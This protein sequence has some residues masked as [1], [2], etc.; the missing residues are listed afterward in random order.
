MRKMR[1]FCAQK[2]FYMNLKS[3]FMLGKTHVPHRK[4]TAGT[5]PVR[6]VGGAEILLPVSQHIG[7]PSSV[8]VKAGDAVKV[9]TLVAEAGGYVGAPIYSSVSGVVKKIE[10]FLTSDGRKCDAVLIENDGLMTPDDA[11]APPE[12]NDIDS[13]AAAIK[14]SGVVG[15]GGAGF[16]SA[17]K[18]DAAKRGLI[19]KII[20]NGAECEPYITSDTNT[21]LYK[22]EDIKAGVELL[23]K[24][25]GADDVIIGIENNKP[26]CIENMKNI[27]IDNSRVSVS[28]L[29]S[30]YPQ[31]GEKVLIYNTTGLAVPEGG[32]PADVGVLV[33]NVTTVA[34]IASYVRTGMPLVEKCITVD[35]SAVSR[36]KNVIAPIGTRISDILEFMGVDADGIGKILSGGPMMGVAVYSAESPIMKNTNAITLMNK[37]DAVSAEPTPCIHCGR[38]VA[39]C[40]MG[41][42]PTVF[43]KSQNIP[44]EAEKVERLK[45][46][47]IN[48]CIECGCCS[49]VCPAKRPL[50]QKNRLGKDDIRQYD[51]KMKE[52]ED[53]KNAEK[54]VAK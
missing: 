1:P 52:F 26:K 6:F 41:L 30:T 12:I 24:Y 17:V 18:L 45:S 46:A 9:G 54:E 23:L 37:R 8:T 50:V 14:A 40:P 5:E 11:I 16:P 2:G 21:M 34:F 35:G 20:I 49:Y 13:L 27:F 31:G 42:N 7:A 39:A 3:L 53:K 28:V 38:C 51:R 25:T 4:N 36:P 44:D 33:F 29:P 32:L 19:K 10:V 48:L 43:A 15:L 22:G 47:K